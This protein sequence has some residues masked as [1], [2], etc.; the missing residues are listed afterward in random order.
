M[1][2]HA[3]AAA[4]E[5]I[6]RSAGVFRLKHAVSV[7]ASDQILTGVSSRHFGD[8]THTAVFLPLLVYLF[9]VFFKLGSS[10]TVGILWVEF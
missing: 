8:A 4:S 2:H 3:A 9:L 6:A 1:P 10:A 7:T 5:A